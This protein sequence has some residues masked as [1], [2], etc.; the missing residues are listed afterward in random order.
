MTET[1]PS[2]WPDESGYDDPT[3][4]YDPHSRTFVAE[5]GHESDVFLRHLFYRR[6]GRG[7][8]QPLTSLDR[9]QSQEQF[10]L[11]CRS[12]TGAYLT[13]DL[14][15]DADGGEWSGIVQYDL[16]HEEVTRRWGR[17]ELQAPRG[18]EGIGYVSEILQICQRG[19]KLRCTA[20]LFGAPAVDESQ[21]EA[22]GYDF[23]VG[24]LDLQSGELELLAEMESAFC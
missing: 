8:Y 22:S 5:F 14:E 11:D 16:R 12:S 19:Q 4:H 7:S 21:P 2:Y 1:R 20:A 3:V 17:D 9:G 23:W 10:A 15:G 24:A 13:L 18:Y 6:E